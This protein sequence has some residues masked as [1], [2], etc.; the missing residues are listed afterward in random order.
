MPLNQSEAEK[1]AKRLGADEDFAQ[2]AEEYSLDSASNN[3][4]GDLG[5]LTPE[6]VEDKFGQAIP[7]LALNELS[8]PIYQENVSKQSGYWLIRVLDKDERTLS[9]DHWNSLANEA[10]NDWIQSKMAES[11]IKDYSDY[12][13]VTWA[14]DHL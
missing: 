2:L 5:W 14:L 3:N 11:R 9:Y 4:G 12:E 8:E 7:L 13:R 10:F 1:I 6:E